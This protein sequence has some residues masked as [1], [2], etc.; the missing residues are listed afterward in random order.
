MMAIYLCGITLCNFGLHPPN[1][2]AGLFLKC[3]SL[4]GFVTLLLNVGGHALLCAFVR[5]TLAF[6]PLSQRSHKGVA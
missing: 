5:I 6:S 2:A 4:K 1:I 3:Q